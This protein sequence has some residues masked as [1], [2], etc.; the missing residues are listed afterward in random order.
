LGREWGDCDLLKG[1][2]ISYGRK[3]KEVS[4]MAGA[5]VS[6]GGLRGACRY[7]LL[8]GQWGKTMGNGFQL[9]DGGK[10]ASSNQKRFSPRPR[11][12]EGEEIVSDVKADEGH[13]KKAEEK[14][15]GGRKHGRGRTRRGRWEGKLFTCGERSL[16]SKVTQSYK[17]KSDSQKGRLEHGGGGVPHCPQSHL[18][19]SKATSCKGGRGNSTVTNSS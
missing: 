5:G 4:I 7:L 16:V 13:R 3:R 18:F 15:R 9:R 11:K 6:H 10:S 12:G 14:M 2:S 1:G 17:K 19:Y 8:F